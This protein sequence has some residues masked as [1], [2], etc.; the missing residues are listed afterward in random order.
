MKHPD[1][2]IPSQG[3]HIRQL[4]R[5]WENEL[6]GEEKDR[7]MKGYIWSGTVEERHKKLGEMH[8]EWKHIQSLAHAPSP[9]L[10]GLNEKKRRRH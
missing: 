7:L 3:Q 6:S 1:L 2:S 5:W 9:L 8:K 10:S 4:I